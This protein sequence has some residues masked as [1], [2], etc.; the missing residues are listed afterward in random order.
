MGARP[1]IV[2]GTAQQSTHKSI[3]IDQVNGNVAPITTVSD[4]LAH[5]PTL[6]ANRTLGNIKP[7]S[8]CTDSSL[9]RYYPDFARQRAAPNRHAAVLDEDANDLMLGGGSSAKE[10]NDLGWLIK[11][12]RADGEKKKPE[13]ASTS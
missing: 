9:G 7:A 11:T 10:N 8:K 13:T 3:P 12:K 2:Q 6:V 1:V 5:P 4:T